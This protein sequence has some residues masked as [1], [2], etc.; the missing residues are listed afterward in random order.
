MY[1]T[2]DPVDVALATLAAEEEAAASAHAMML[3]TS[4]RAPKGDDAMRARVA[5]ALAHAPRAHRFGAARGVRA[6][7][8]MRVM[9]PRK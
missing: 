9:Q 5:K 7:K 6:R 2:L 8:M 3:A 4:K 1:E